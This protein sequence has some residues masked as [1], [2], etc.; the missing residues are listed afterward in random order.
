MLFYVQVNIY[1][2]LVIDINRSKKKR[3]KT[4]KKKLCFVRF[5]FLIDTTS[6]EVIGIDF[7]SAF[8]AAT[9]VNSQEFPLINMF[10]IKFSHFS[11]FARARIDSN[12]FDSSINRTHV[13]NRYGRSLS[14]DNDSYNECPTRKQ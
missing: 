6:G 14:C 5:S 4:K 3:R 12:S 2:E 1:L 13:A 11:A 9:I 7:G 10:R 8:N